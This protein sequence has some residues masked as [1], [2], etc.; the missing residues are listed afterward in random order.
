MILVPPPITGLTELVELFDG[1]ESKSLKFPEHYQRIA[2][3]TG[4]TFLDTGTIIRSSP[5]DGIHLEEAGH[6][7]LGEAVAL[8]VK[9]TLAV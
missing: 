3:Q 5:L 7:K 6:F 1:A 2:R 9:E 4:C 8:K